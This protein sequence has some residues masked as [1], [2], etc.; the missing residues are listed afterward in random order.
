MRFLNF[1]KRNVWNIFGC[2]VLLG[3]LLVL[4]VIFQGMASDRDNMNICTKNGYATSVYLAGDTWCYRI[5]GDSG[6]LTLVSTLKGT[7]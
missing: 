5:N 3:F 6:I 1:L 2:V 7:K 4:L